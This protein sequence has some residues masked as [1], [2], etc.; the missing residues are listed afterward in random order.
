[1]ARLSAPDIVLSSSERETLEQIVRKR[2]NP[3]H[4]VTRAKLILA[5]AQ[6][7]GIRE[8]A[9]TLHLARDMVQRWRRRWLQTQAIAAI[10]TRLADAPRPGAPATYTPEQIC[11]IVALACE[12]PE[13]S[14]IP[15]THWTQ[16]GLAEEAVRRGL[17]PAVSQRAV[18]HFLKGGRPPAA[19]RARLAQYR[20]GCRV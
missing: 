5:A 1:M 20:Q 4:L 17:A 19:S 15:V 2:S 13:D 8:T 12:R 11:A 3:Q 16:Q 10:E 18:G 14:G 7:Q 9:R 6:G